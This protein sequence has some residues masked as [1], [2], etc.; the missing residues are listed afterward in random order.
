MLCLILQTLRQLLY[1]KFSYYDTYLMEKVSYLT[2]NKKLIFYI[3]VENQFQI[4]V[5]Y[6]HLYTELTKSDLNENQNFVR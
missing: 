1:V 6:L 4:N 5:I 3:N 2:L